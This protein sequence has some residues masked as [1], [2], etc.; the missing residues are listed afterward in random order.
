MP[1]N[2]PCPASFGRTEKFDLEVHT[3]LKACFIAIAVSICRISVSSIK[4]LM[5]DTNDQ[6]RRNSIGRAN[7][8]P[9]LA[10]GKPPPCE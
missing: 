2:K 4:P 5:S 8:L 10:A 6:A 3:N 1:V 9:S 7:G